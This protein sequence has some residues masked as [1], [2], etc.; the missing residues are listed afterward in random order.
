MSW[1]LENQLTAALNRA[2]NGLQQ[3]VLAT[4]VAAMSDGYRA[5]L[6]NE[7]RIGMNDRLDALAYAVFRMPATTA[8]IW[9]T[10]G[11]ARATSPDMRPLRHLDL[12]G[13]TGAAAWAAAAVWP[14]IATTTVERSV[15]AVDVGRSLMRAEPRLHVSQKGWIKQ[16]LRTWTAPDSWDLVTL[17]Y[18]LVELDAPARAALVAEAARCARTVVVVEPGTPRG[19]ARVLE[20]RATLIA[21][22][23]TIAAPCPHQEGCPLA[24]GP[25]WCHFAVRLARSPL[26]RVLK[27]GTRDFEQEVY[28]YAVATRAVT[29]RV[30]A[31]LI[32]QPRKPK[33]QVILDVCGRDGGRHR[34]SIPKSHE[35]YR[36]ARDAGWGD[37]W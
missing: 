32:G 10:L 26:H 17:A 29:S 35:R 24:S 11:S 23:F 37:A 3:H 5:E 14:G 12:G 19:Y 28:S 13:G 18:V 16:D 15:P 4:R 9:A 22:G 21:K 31:R 27:G 25:A 7:H 30:E 20:A 8:A 6:I 2:T 1:P 33:G 36:E 34:L